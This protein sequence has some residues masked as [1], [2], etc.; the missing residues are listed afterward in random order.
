MGGGDSLF[1]LIGVDEDEDEDDDD[2]KYDDES[3]SASSLLK[4]NR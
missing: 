1:V 2:E 3:L 4:V